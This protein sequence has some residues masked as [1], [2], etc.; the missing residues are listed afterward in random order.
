MEHTCNT[1]KY[2]KT[3][4][5]LPFVQANPQCSSAAWDNEKILLATEK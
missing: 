3:N 5:F 4:H 2:N 1:G